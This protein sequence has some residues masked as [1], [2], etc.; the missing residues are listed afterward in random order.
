[1]LVVLQVFQEGWV[2]LCCR[3][4]C[5]RMYADEITA[6]TDSVRAVFVQFP[7]KPLLQLSVGECTGRL[8]FKNRVRPEKCQY[9][10]WRF[11]CVWHRISFPIMPYAVYLPFTDK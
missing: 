4:R 6:H 1:M 5:P 3:R 10:Q 2:R 7:G 9:R 11:R 8:Y